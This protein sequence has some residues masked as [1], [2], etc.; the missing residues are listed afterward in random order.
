M[1]YSKPLSYQTPLPY[2]ESFCTFICPSKRLLNSWCGKNL[3]FYGK[4]RILATLIDSIHSRIVILCMQ[5][6]A[7]FAD[8]IHEVCVSMKKNRVLVLK[9]FPPYWIY[10][11]ACKSS[12]CM[13]WKSVIA[14]NSCIK[15]FFNEY[16]LIGSHKTH[17][18]LKTSL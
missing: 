16:S 6:G 2:L 4:S 13:F 18:F 15:Y 8:F 14:N 17:T 7:W 1:L 5:V 9:Y 11:K 10:I 12:T 3:L